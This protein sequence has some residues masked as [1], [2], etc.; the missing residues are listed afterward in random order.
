MSDIFLAIIIL[1]LCVAVISLVVTADD[2]DQRIKALEED[3][4]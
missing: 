2:H 3:G 1:G 4:E